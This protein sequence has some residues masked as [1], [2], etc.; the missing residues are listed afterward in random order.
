ML[1]LLSLSTLFLI[2]SMV[3]VVGYV[4][5]AK[6][7]LQAAADA[8]A[9]AGAGKLCSSHEC[10]DA[11]YAATLFT[12]R[13]QASRGAFGAPTSYTFTP[14]PLVPSPIYIPNAATPNLIVTVEMGMWTDQGF[15]PFYQANPSA[16]VPHSWQEDHPGVPQYVAA[17]AVRVSLTRPLSIP[18]VSAI[19]SNFQATAQTTM[20]AQKLNAPSAAPFALPVCALVDEYSEVNFASVCAADRLFTSTSR[21]CPAGTNCDVATNVPPCCSWVPSFT[22]DPYEYGDVGLN[23]TDPRLTC[24]FDDAST[25]YKCRYVTDQ[26]CGWNENRYLQLGDHFGVVGLP[27]AVGDLPPTE[28]DVVGALSSRG[29]ST[30]LGQNF[31]ILENGLTSISAED[32]LWNTIDQPSGSMGAD[33]P[34]YN[35]T[36]LANSTGLPDTSTTDLSYLVQFNPYVASS[37]SSNSA[38]TSC[39]LLESAAPYACKVGSLC[40][41][42]GD[43]GCAPSVSPPVAAVGSHTGEIS[44]AMGPHTNNGICNSRRF[45]PQPTPAPGETPIEPQGIGKNGEKSVWFTSVPIIADFGSAAQACASVASSSGPSGA[46]LYNDP[47]VISSGEGHQWRVIGFV[48]TDIYDVDIGKSPPTFPSPSL[49]A[50]LG[51]LNPDPTTFKG[52]VWPYGWFPTSGMPTTDNPWGFPVSCNLVRARARCDTDFFP[53]DPQAARSGFGERQPIAVE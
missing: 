35:Q 16:G 4:T 28:S 21:Y 23:N 53:G 40:C 46:T 18:V 2:A 45:G 3:S 1:L 52:L 50:K 22:W 30:K 6:T 32:A 38:T 49:V 41:N 29:V 19:R 27:G 51:S 20:V 39:L 5:L 34:P 48:R 33:R 8:A 42:P 25:P 31:L 17:N 24:G 7:E 10:Y 43:V 36:P 11:A 13:H 26:H 9:F 12:L 44:G 15:E 37:G 14:D 47:Y